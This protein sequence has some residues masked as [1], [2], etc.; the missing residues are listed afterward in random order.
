MVWSRVAL[1]RIPRALA[2]R[3]PKVRAQAN[4]ASARHFGFQH[5]FRCLAQIEYQSPHFVLHL[6]FGHSIHREIVLDC[7]AIHVGEGAPVCHGT[8]SIAL[9]GPV[10]LTIGTIRG[11]HFL[12][13]CFL[14]FTFLT[15]PI[16]LRVFL[17]FPSKRSSTA[18]ITPDI[19]RL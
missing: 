12:S 8:R 19:S 7:L 17:S 3:F 2:H 13:R 6:E 16:S 18:S 1:A 10:R 5:N 14:P 15:P 9:S 4:S 11:D